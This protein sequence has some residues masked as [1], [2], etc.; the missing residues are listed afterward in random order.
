MNIK[1]KGRRFRKNVAPFLEKNKQW[2]IN[3]QPALAGSVDTDGALTEAFFLRKW[4]DFGQSLFGCPDKE[5]F[6]SLLKSTVR[7]LPFQGI[8]KAVGSLL[9]CEG[10][11]DVCGFF[12]CHR[13]FPLKIICPTR[14]NRNFASSIEHITIIQ[15]KGV[16]VNV[17]KDLDT[18]YW[19]KT[20][21]YYRMSKNN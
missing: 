19:L 3:G 21:M 20:N 4:P 6:S 17:T 16:K 15:Q 18:F 9:V 10:N 13:S 1:K 5:V 7:K 12:V 14:T 8:G 2:W 11:L